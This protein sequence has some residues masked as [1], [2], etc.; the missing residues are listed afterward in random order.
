M[1]KYKGVNKNLQPLRSPHVVAAM[2]NGLVGK[3]RREVP[4][5]LVV[6]SHVEPLR[7]GVLHLDGAAARVDVAAVQLLSRPDRRLQV[8]ELH[9]GLHTSV[10]N[11]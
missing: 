10:P 4:R 5:L 9:H 2:L 11:P 7:L 6:L 1:S 8:A 3:I